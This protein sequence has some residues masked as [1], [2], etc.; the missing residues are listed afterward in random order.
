[1]E[2]RPRTFR[3]RS[4]TSIIAP[5]EEVDDDVSN[6]SSGCNSLQQASDC[7]LSLEVQIAESLE[8]MLT[9]SNKYNSAL[10]D[11]K[12]LKDG[13]AQIRSELPVHSKTRRKLLEECKLRLKGN[14]SNQSVPSSRSI[15][16]TVKK[17]HEDNRK[18]VKRRKNDERKICANSA[19]VNKQFHCLIGKSNANSRSV[20]TVKQ[21][22]SV[23]ESRRPN[24]DKRGREMGDYNGSRGY[25]E[26]EASET[27]SDENLYYKAKLVNEDG[28]EVGDTSR[29]VYTTART[30][31]IRDILKCQNARKHKDNS[32]EPCFCQHCGMADVLIE[33][34]KR[35]ITDETYNT[36]PDFIR[37][38][39][40]KKEDISPRARSRKEL[41]GRPDSNV[42]VLFEKLKALEMVLQQQEEKFVTKEYL[43]V[44]VDKIISYISPKVNRSNSSPV[45][46]NTGIQC[47][48]TFPRRDVATLKINSLRRKQN[49]CYVGSAL[50]V[51]RHTSVGHS[52]RETVLSDKSAEHLSRCEEFARPTHQ[53]DVFWKWGDETVRPGF[54]MKEKIAQLINERFNGLKPTKLAYSENVDKP[55]VDVSESSSEKTL[56]LCGSENQ[57]NTIG[58]RKHSKVSFNDGDNKKMLDIMSEKIY[59]EYI[60]N[61]KKSQV[62]QQIK[63]SRDVKK[64]VDDIVFKR[65]VENAKKKADVLRQN[66]EQ[67]SEAKGSRDCGSNLPVKKVPSQKSV[68]KSLI[69]KY[70]KCDRKQPCE[71]NSSSRVRVTYMSPKAETWKQDSCMC[72]KVEQHFKRFLNGGWKGPISNAGK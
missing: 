40:R 25:L 60:N 19:P 67:Q 23:R 38:D 7:D 46:K 20:E 22:G 2:R 63:F 12:L 1:M 62:A 47:S 24:N 65:N 27:S 53:G 17:K 10:V 29:Q 64:A 11:V 41:P 3:R 55:D 32:K 16:R 49:D 61:Q 70:K 51:P 43:K 31:N 66:V 71:T 34:Q 56:Y 57:A 28:I 36:T 13:R 33:S 39:S 21:A 45:R 50:S 69:P 54:D 6:Y 8:R 72:F 44:V 15:H 37:P 48:K 18:T 35:L 42:S 30:S 4:N 59:T 52:D 5:N 9:S 14:S 58:H 26:E 68:R